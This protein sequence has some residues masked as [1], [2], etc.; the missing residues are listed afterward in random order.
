MKKLGIIV[1]GFVLVSLVAVAIRLAVP[2]AIAD[3]ELGLSPFA[4]LPL[5][6][7]RT[8][9]MLAPGQSRWYALSPGSA[10]AFQ[11]Q[12]DLTLFFT[13]DNGSRA[14]GVSF[15]IFPAEQITHW[16]AGDVSQM[17]NM[18][19][20]GVVSR[21]GN[22]VTGELLWSGWI[23]NSET[24]YV[25]V[26]NGVDV[27]IDY[28]LFTGDVIAAE[29]GPDPEPPPVQE[30]VVEP[31]LDPAPASQVVQEM[32]LEVEADNL[33]PLASEQGGDQPTVAP[34]VE[35]VPSGMPTRLVIPAIALD[36]GVVSVDRQPVVINGVTYGQ[37]N[38]ADDMVG[39][40]SLS[41]KLGYGGNTVFN[42]HSDVHAAVFRNLQYALVGDEILVYSGAQEY[43]YVVTHRFLLQEED[44]SL[45]VRLQNAAWIASTQEERLT[46][47]TCAQPGATHRLILVAQPVSDTR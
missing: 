43:R 42:G 34:G 21:D 7:G 25:Q 15:Q 39:W 16:Y 41:A 37:W 29:L 38:T 13:P 40:H 17:Q 4:A 12:L 28:W 23:V 2:K 32:P 8:V 35:Y 44:V 6:D 14:Y 46:L 36:S 45:E 1:G 26:S 24:Y 18:G 5:H 19:A 27:T 10:D 47:V 22:P 33:L 30:V 3:A 11:K 20:G 31:E 9:G